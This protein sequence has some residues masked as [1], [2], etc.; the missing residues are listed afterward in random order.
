[1]GLPEGWVVVMDVERGERGAGRDGVSSSDDNR[2]EAA[3]AAVARTA[4]INTTRSGERWKDI[5]K[6]R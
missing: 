3:L 4:V 2:V 6:S 5:S 1:V